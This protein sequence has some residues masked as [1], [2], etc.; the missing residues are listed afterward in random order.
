[1]SEYNFY[2]EPGDPPTLNFH[3]TGMHGR[4][5]IDE[6][7]LEAV[8]SSVLLDADEE[9]LPFALTE[10]D[11]EVVLPEGASALSGI[12]LAVPEELPQGTLLR[13]RGR[14]AAQ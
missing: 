6:Q 13:L 7:T 1:M 2:L 3:Y 12:T 10:L 14:R 9:G 11:I 8:T 5:I 4:E